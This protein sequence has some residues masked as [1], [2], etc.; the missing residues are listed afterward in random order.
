MREQLKNWIDSMELQNSI[1]SALTEALFSK[2][3]ECGCSIQE[4]QIFTEMD[5]IEFRQSPKRFL[6]NRV[7]VGTAADVGEC[8]DSSSRRQ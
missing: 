4:A 8:C 6:L 7:N 3:L 2:Y 1:E 5:I